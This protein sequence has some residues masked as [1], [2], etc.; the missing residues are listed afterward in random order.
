LPDLPA[1]LAVGLSVSVNDA[2]EE[3]RGGAH[4]VT[5]ALGGHGAIRETVEMILKAQ[6]RWADIIRKYTS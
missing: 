3:V 5:K 2:A 6:G 1:M 4:Y